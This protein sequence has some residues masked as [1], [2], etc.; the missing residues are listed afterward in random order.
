VA[1]ALAAAATLGLGWAVTSNASA[2]DGSR[3]RSAQD[4][5]QHRDCPDKQGGTGAETSV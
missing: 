1:V 3:G 4:A 2:S 5:Q